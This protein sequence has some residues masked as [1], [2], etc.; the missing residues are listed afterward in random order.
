[1]HPRLL[2]IPFSNL[3]KSAR[4]GY[5]SKVL[6]E[7]PLMINVHKIFGVILIPNFQ[8]I[9]AYST[10]SKPGKWATS[11]FKLTTMRTAVWQKFITMTY[12]WTTQIHNS[13]RSSKPWIILVGWNTTFQKQ[14]QLHKKTN[15]FQWIRK[16]F[17][18]ADF[19]G[20]QFRFKES[21]KGLNSSL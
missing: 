15:N 21:I 4:L 2:Q 10:I 20:Y 6:C 7:T 14:R 8:K 11:H 17:K 1:M 13:N 16:D 19:K 3:F 12:C 5:L 18:S 9:T